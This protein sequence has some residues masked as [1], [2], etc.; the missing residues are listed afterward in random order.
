[1]KNKHSFIYAFAL[2]VKKG[3]VGRSKHSN[4]GVDKSNPAAGP[5]RHVGGF[6]TDVITNVL[7]TLRPRLGSHLRL[8]ASGTPGPGHLALGNWG[9]GAT[10]KVGRD[11]RSFFLVPHFAKLVP[12]EVGDWGCVGS[13]TSGNASKFQGSISS[14]S[15][16]SARRGN[17][18][19][20]TWQE[21]T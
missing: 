7:T 2:G 3:G 12:K 6:R 19:H 9:R 14:K 15:S 13:T 18:I 16:K 17:L 11:T 1:M 4:L 10:P 5:T 8:G 20:N 21:V